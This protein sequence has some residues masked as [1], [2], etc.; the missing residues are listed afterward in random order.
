MAPRFRPLLNRPVVERLPRYYH[1]VRDVARPRGDEVVSSDDLA[2]ALGVDSTLVRRDL[3]QI[4]VQGR[5]RVGFR[6]DAVLRAIR[7]AL[8]FDRQTPAILVGAGR[9]GSALAS[10]A[11]FSEYGLRLVAAFDI[12]PS[13]VGE[14][15]GGVPIYALARLEA[16]IAAEGV[17]IAI[18]TAP[19]SAAQEIADRLVKAG[20]RTIWNFAPVHLKH[21]SSVKVRNELIAIGW[22]ELSHFLTRLNRSAKP[23]ASMAHSKSVRR[24]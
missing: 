19:E 20:V 10:Y 3:A 13:L 23:G 7:S 6:C 17:E 15:I 16:M 12:R 22:A 11:G 9:L 21:P 2:K 5:P 4:G 18:L 14:T 1:Y 8:G 24:K